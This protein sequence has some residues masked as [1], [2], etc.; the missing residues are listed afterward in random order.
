MP[1]TVRF[2]SRPADREAAFQ[3]RQAV[4]DREQHVPRPLDRDANDDNARHALVYDERGRPV[5]TGRVV[6][7]DSRTAQIGRMAVLPEHRRTGAGAAILSALEHVAALNGLGELFVDSQLPA[8]PF[9][10]ARGY[11]PDGEPFR[12]C[13]VPHVRMR[14][15]LIRPS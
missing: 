3:I 1:Y 12:D 9:Y 8:Q 14:K 6:R 11:V 13:G 10:A 15:T 5:G 4:F 2:A 7:L